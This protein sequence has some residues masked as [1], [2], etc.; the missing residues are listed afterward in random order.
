VL[1]AAMEVDAAAT[2]AL[3]KKMRSGARETAP[4]K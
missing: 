3:R 1:N 4:A 2:T